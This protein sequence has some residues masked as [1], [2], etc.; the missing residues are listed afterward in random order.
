MRA[1]ADRCSSFASQER[2]AGEANN[3]N[4]H[5][6]RFAKS[7]QRTANNEQRSPLPRRRDLNISIRIPPQ[8]RQSRQPVLVANRAPHT[9]RIFDRQ[10]SGCRAKFR[11]RNS[12]ANCARR[13]FNLR[14]IPYPLHLAKL[15]IRHE[16]QLVALF[17]EPDRRRH[18]DPGFTKGGER[19]IFLSVN[20][21]GDGHSNIVIN[22]SRNTSGGECITPP[23]EAR[24]VIQ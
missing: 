14:V 11:P 20:R 4:I 23:E 15:A 13:N 10:N 5:D 3:S 16:V 17:C 9:R 7:N 18:R 2:T 6:E 22:A 12:P 8:E 19:N 21:S 24:A 1:E